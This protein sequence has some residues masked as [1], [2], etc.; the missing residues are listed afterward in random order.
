MDKKAF[1]LR[2]ESHWRKE[3]DLD[4]EPELIKTSRILDS[5]C[6]NRISLDPELVDLEAGGSTL[7]SVLLTEGFGHGEMQCC[8]SMKFWYGSG[9]ADPYLWLMDPDPFADSD[10]AIFV[11][12]LQDVKKL[13]FSKFFAYYFLKIHLHQFSKWK[14]HKEVTKQ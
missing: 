8:G 10:P 3:P 2:L 1:F 11:S 9:S 13:F 4:P 6:L 7:M 12:D 5:V 14:S